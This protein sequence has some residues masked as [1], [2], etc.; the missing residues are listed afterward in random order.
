MKAF[1]IKYHFIKSMI[2]FFI[3]LCLTVSNKNTRESVTTKGIDSGFTFSSST[4]QMLLHYVI[5]EDKR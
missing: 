2:S 5:A 3:V 1:S 4:W